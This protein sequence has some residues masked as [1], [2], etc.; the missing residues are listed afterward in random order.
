MTRIALVLLLGIS[1]LISFSVQADGRGKHYKKQ[2]Y[3]PHNKHQVRYSHHQRQHYR[4]HGHH[5]Y[6]H[7]YRPYGYRPQGCGYGSQYIHGGYPMISGVGYIA[8]DSR[9]GF[10]A[11]GEAVLRGSYP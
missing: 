11:G 3:A 5:N 1:M 10:S 9:H 4:S 6:S 8:L 7:G 2:Y